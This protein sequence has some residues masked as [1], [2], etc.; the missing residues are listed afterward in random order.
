MVNTVLIYKYTELSDQIVQPIKWT[1]H[2]PIFKVS[3]PVH[4]VA[5]LSKA[6]ACFLLDSLM[7]YS[8]IPMPFI[9]SLHINL[10]QDIADVAVGVKAPT[11]LQYII[12]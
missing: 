2:T 6:G 7:K 4:S 5:Q 12:A 11:H 3:C 10:F 8:V 9:F 1:D